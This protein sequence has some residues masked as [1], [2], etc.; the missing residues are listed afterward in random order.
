MLQFSKDIFYLAFKY[1]NTLLSTLFCP[2]Y[3]F[4][5][6]QHFLHNTLY[7]YPEIIVIGGVPYL[8]DFNLKINTMESWFSGMYLHS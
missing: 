5:L 8:H 3:Q 1:I 7:I 6:T 4:F 2:P